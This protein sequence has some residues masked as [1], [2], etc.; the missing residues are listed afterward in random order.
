M[1]ETFAKS[2]IDFIVPAFN[3]EDGIRQTSQK[4][5]DLVDANGL[6]ASIIFID[7]GSSDGTWLVLSELARDDHRIK[8]LR[9]SRNFGHQAAITAGL[10]HSHADFSM[11]IDADL[12]DPPELL[13][14]MLKIASQGY[15]IVYGI[16]TEREGESVAKKIT[17][18][19][20]YRV[21][22]FFLP[23]NM[24]C[25]AGDFRLVSAKAREAF[26]QTK[27][28]SRLNREIWAWTGLSQ[29]GIEFERPPRLFGKT[30][31]NYKRMLK[32]ALDGITA[33]G[34]GPLWTI[35]F[36]AYAMIMLSLILL[37]IAP[38]IS[39]ITF[40]SALILDFIALIGIY[41]ARL[42]RQSRNRPTY[43]VSEVI[44]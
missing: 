36:L 31:Y 9:F 16:R 29:T 40:A 17:A 38:L 41:V 22:N 5:I 8:V 15:H 39:A 4:L 14:K 25:D 6:D 2:S 7:D 3:E 27:E 35:K 19:M 30:K 42:Y 34:E 44:S 12:Q 11:I 13:P 20:F 33:S 23:F 43:I 1:E 28:I 10:S 21:I 26:L 32:L 18:K 24:P 37:F